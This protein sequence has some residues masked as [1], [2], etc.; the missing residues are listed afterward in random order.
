[1][2]QRREREKTYVHITRK[3]LLA[4]WTNLNV[5]ELQAA[6]GGQREKERERRRETEKERR[7]TEKEEKEEKET[8]KRERNGGKYKHDNIS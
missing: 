5:A 6:M 1:M 4:G 7:E 3:S 8:D 2:L